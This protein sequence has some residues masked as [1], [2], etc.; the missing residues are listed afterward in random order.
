MKGSEKAPLCLFPTNVK[1]IYQL[2]PV[3]AKNFMASEM[4]LGLG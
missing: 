4:L 1:E 3:K 2:M